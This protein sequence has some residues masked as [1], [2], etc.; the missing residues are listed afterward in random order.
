MVDDGGE[1]KPSPRTMVL[2][3]R[4]RLLPKASQ[5]RRL[6]EIC[7]SQRLLYNAALEERIGAWRK[8][9]KSITFFDQSKSLAEWRGF[10]DEASSLPSN[11]QRWTLAKV[12]DAFTG[13]FSRIRGNNGKAGFPRFRSKSRW[14]S[15]GFKEFSG[16]RLE[17]RYLRFKGMP[18]SRS[19]NWWF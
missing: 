1:V 6:E 11:L 15:F 12:N 2:T 9:G 8:A 7:E 16:I 4:Y 14:R 10:D 3:W 17:G 13:F 18:A 19:G 5:Y